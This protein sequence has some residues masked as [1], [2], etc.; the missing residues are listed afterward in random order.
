MDY[1]FVALSAQRGSKFSHRQHGGFVMVV[2]LI[3]LVILTLIGISGMRTTRA[4][5]QMTG[6]RFERVTALTSS[7]AGLSDGR[8]YVLQPDF[9]PNSGAF[10]VRDVSTSALIGTTGEG[11]TVNSWVLANTDWYTGPDALPFGTGNGETYTLARVNRNP[12]FIVDRLPSEQT[13]NAVP[14]QIFRV[15]AR[16]EGARAENAALTQS[17]IRIPVPQ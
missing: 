8:D 7:H 14:Y 16:G 13:Q 15:T 5:E 12:A 9:D 11:W 4:Q 3:F 1:S 6:G 2:V 10:R 17:I